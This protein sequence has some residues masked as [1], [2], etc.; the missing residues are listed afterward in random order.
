MRQGGD[1][2]VRRFNFKWWRTS[3]V[4][5]SIGEHLDLLADPVSVPYPVVKGYVTV[6]PD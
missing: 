2:E 1:V 5:E 4:Q 3:S 6:T